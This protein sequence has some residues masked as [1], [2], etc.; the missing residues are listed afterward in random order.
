MAH[1]HTKEMLLISIIFINLLV[2]PHIVGKPIQNE[3][4]IDSLILLPASNSI[5]LVDDQETFQPKKQS[6]I[7]D[8]I[9]KWENAYKTP[10]T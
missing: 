5:K 10:I 3:V 7:Q 2:I 6:K 4:K 1:T 9:I 8:P